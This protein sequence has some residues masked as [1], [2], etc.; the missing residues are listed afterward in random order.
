MNTIERVI[1]L[2]LLPNRFRGVFVFLLFPGI[3]IVGC[4]LLNNSMA[5]YF[6]DHTGIVEV[7]G[8]TVKTE[9]TMMSDGMIFIPSGSAKMG[10]NLSNPRNFSV[11]QE[12]LGIPEGKN[13]S[14]KQIGTAEIEVNIDGA[15]EGDEYA[16]TLVMQSSDGLR[17]FPAYSMRIKCVSF[18]TALQDFTVNGATPPAFDPAKD[19]FQAD[20][21]YSGALVTL[22]G[23]TAHQDAVIEIY[24]GTNDSGPVLA[25]GT[26]TAEIP[27]NL[28]PGNNYVYVKVI[29]PSSGSRGYAVTVY[30]A[31]N[32]DKA[33]TAF[34]ITGPVSAT[35]NVDEALKT[36][37]VNV[38]YGTNVTAMTATVSHTGASISPDPAVAADY[39]GGKTYTVTAVDGSTQAYTVTVNAAPG[40]TISGISVEGLSALTF[41]GVP[42]SVAPG[43]PINVTLSG[44]VTVDGWYIE[45]TGPSASTVNAGAF[46]APL[47][48]GFYNINVIAT[49]GAVDYSGSFALI[50]D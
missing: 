27:W 34:S 17:D 36:I 37:T 1:I 39:S 46:S 33:I 38:P 31:M 23:V 21:P 40:I 3:V 4:D 19:A 42:S 9:Y 44:G 16:L 10:L 24:A 11:R 6:L 49:V 5:D 32:S 14:S 41:S 48:P 18:E 13:I 43:A 47:T 26:H 15:V 2:K 29:A 20:V 50:V 22:R 12:L 25:R 7:T 28:E 8:L 35:G 30:R 45:I